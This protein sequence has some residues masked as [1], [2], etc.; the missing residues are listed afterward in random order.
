MTSTTPTRAIG[1]TVSP[2]MTHAQGDGHDGQEV[3]RDRGPRAAHAAGQRGHQDEGHAACP[4]RP[5]AASPAPP[6]TTTTRP[7]SCARPM[8]ATISQRHQLHPEDDRQR[9][10]LLLQRH[11]QV[12]GQT[13]ERDGEQRHGRHRPPRR[14]RLQLRAGRPARCRRSRG[15]CP[16][17]GASPAARRSRY[18]AQA[19]VKM[20]MAPLIMPVTLE[21][22]DCCA[23]GNSV[24]GRA[25]QT[26]PRRAMRPQSSPL[27]RG[28]GPGE[29]GQRARRRGAMRASVMTP[30]AKERRPI[31]TNRNDEPQMSAM[32]ASRPQSPSV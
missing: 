32:A 6:P 1:A 19:A 30:G 5:A 7:G 12:G 16:A 9:A 11:R 28:P 26:T 31:S 3:D 10:V 22:I 23:M 15:R 2:R 17:A 8:G 25:I 27:D 18:V 14:S 29:Q 20:G 13:V 21:L 24:S 4:A